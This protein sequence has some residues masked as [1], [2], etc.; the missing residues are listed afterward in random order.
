[1]VYD[2]LWRVAPRLQVA[3]GRINQGTFEVH[4]GI[5]PTS[6]V[7]LRYGFPKWLLCDKR[8]LDEGIC[9]LIRVG[10]WTCRWFPPAQNPSTT[11]QRRQSHAGNSRLIDLPKVT[12]ITFIVNMINIVTENS[13]ELIVLPVRSQTSFSIWRF[14]PKIRNLTLQAYTGVPEQVKN[15]ALL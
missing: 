12:N 4:Y 11:P 9:Q 13:I 2:G 7:A 10:S 14:S 6:G 8:S 5:S 1:M 3:R 15:T